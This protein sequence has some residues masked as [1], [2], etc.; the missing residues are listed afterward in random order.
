ME[1]KAAV[2][3]AMEVAVAVCGVAAVDGGDAASWIRPGRGRCWCGSRRRVCAIRI[4][5]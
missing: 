3:A 4:C 2:L 5:R 1:I